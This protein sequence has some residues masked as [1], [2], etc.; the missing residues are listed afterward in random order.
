VFDGSA[1]RLVAHLI[2]E[3]ELDD[4][5]CQEIIDLLKARSDR[6]SS[7]SQEGARP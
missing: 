4:R 3:G 7:P 5:E 1:R 2:Q 6:K